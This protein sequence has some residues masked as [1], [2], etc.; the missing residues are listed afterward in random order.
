MA[1]LSELKLCRKRGDNYPL[2]LTIY[3]DANNTTPMDLTGITVRLVGNTEPDPTDITNQQFAVVGTSTTPTSG[4][5]AF[6]WT[7]A[8]LDYVGVLYIEGEMTL[9]DMSKRT[10]FNGTLTLEQDRA[11]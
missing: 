4:V 8:D 2:E 6:P 7:E 3:T 5:V 9:S 11:K 10:A 1:T